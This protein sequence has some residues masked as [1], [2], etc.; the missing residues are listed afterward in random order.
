MTNDIVW[1]ESATPARSVVQG[2]LYLIPTI[3]TAS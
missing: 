1:I 2:L 3:T